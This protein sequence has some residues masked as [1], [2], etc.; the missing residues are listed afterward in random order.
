MSGVQ[1]E[2][3][4]RTLDAVWRIESAKIIARLVRVV[5]DVEVAEDLAGEA[6]IA[7]LEQWPESGIP[8]NPGAWLTAAAKNR[9]IDYVRRRTLLRQKHEMLAAEDDRSMV[10]IAPALDA[11]LDDNIGDEVLRLVF[12]TCHPVLNTESRVALTLRLVGGLT[13]EEIGR[14]FLTPVATIQQRIVRAKKT[15]NSAQV[16]FEVP[17]GAELRERLAS[18]LETVYL[19]FNE[20]YSAT[21]GDDWMRPQL[22][23]DAMRL[24]RVLTSLAPHEPDVHGL[25]ALMEIQA[26]RLRAR[27]DV[28]GDP[29]L[30]LDQNRAQWDWVLIEHGL[31]A[32]KRAEQ[33]RPKRSNYV[34]QAAISACHA[35][36]R[37]AE[38]TDWKAIAA[39]YDELREVS[40]SP[41][42]DLN[43]SV[44]YAM[45]FGAEHGLQIVDQLRLLPPMQTYHLLYA[46][47]GDLLFRLQRYDEARQEFKRAASLTKNNKE[48][49]VLTQRA[50]ECV[51][52]STAPATPPLDQS[53]P[54]G[55]PAPST[56]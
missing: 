52:K 13:T 8:D 50:Y 18:V 32:L 22:C 35:R 4:T 6:L 17:R 14:A 56:P 48:R 39:L 27:T 26:S 53:A 38:D 44:A 20:G 15:L 41:V 46:V 19:V 34:L 7:A 16:V 24:G 10:H 45:A 30:L 54:H 51:D 49:D 3:I 9:G 33:L 28:N 21:A 12:M 25:V 2:A 11:A 43:R 23:E 40:P 36:A 37:K 55:V 47:R 1:R 42:V 5:G 31:G 29:I